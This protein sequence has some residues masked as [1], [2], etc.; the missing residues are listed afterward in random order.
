MIFL[1]WN[2]GGG[3]RAGNVVHL[4]ATVKERPKF[5]ATLAVKQLTGRALQA[6]GSLKP[7]KPRRG[8]RPGVGEE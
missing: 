1:L 6:D 4:H 2:R 7:P 8:V 5:S 3:V